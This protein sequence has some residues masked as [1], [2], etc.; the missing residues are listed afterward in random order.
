M[1]PDFLAAFADALVLP[2]I[3][4]TASELVPEQSV[5]SR[6]AVGR[7][8]KQAVMLPLDLS[9]GIAQRVQEVV[10]GVQN[11]AIQRELNNGLRFVDGV[12]LPS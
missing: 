11:L 3:E 7:I 5:F 2:G 12:D 9:Q 8:D 1:Y 6:G 4:F 10:V